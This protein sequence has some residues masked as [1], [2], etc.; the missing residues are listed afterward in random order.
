MQGSVLEPFDLMAPTNGLELLERCPWTGKETYIHCDG[1]EFRTIIYEPDTELVKM[2][3]AEQADTLNHRARDDEFVKIGSIP[4]GV[5]MKELA[6]ADRQGDMNYVNR[7]MAEHSD[8]RT[9][10]RY[11]S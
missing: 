7:W 8:Y 3:K 4:T 2:N 9:H 6:E 1:R 10:G 11:A 5:Y